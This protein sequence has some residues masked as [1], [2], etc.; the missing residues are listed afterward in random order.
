MVAAGLGGVRVESAVVPSEPPGG[1]IEGAWG[2]GAPPPTAH[3]DPCGRGE[4]ARPRLAAVRPGRAVHRPAVVPGGRQGPGVL[5]DSRRE[6]RARAGC[7][8]WDRVVPGGESAARVA[9]RRSGAGSGA[10][11]RRGRWRRGAALRPRPLAGA[12]RPT[13]VV[14]P[15]G[16][17]GCLGAQR[18]AARGR[19]MAGAAAVARPGAVRRRRRAVPPRHRLLHLHAAAAAAGLR[20]AAVHPA[21]DVAGHRRELVPARR[22]PAAAGG[23]AGQS[24]G[25][26]APVA[27]AR[28]RA[29]AQDLGLPAGPVLTGV[30][31]PWGGDRCLLHRR[32]RAAPGAAPDGAAG[33]GLRPA[34]LRHDPLARLPAGRQRPGA[35]R[36]VVNPGWRHL[37]NDRAALPGRAAGAAAGAA[38]HP[39]QPRRHPQGV[40]AGSRHDDRVRRRGAPASRSPAGRPGHGRQ[41]PPVGA[42][43][44]QDRHPEPAGDRPVLPVQR[45]RRRP[46]PDRGH[47]APGDDLR[48]RRRPAQPGPVRA[49]LAEP[50]PR[51]HPRLWGGGRPG[52][53]RGGVGTAVVCGQRL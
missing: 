6:V 18:R 52:Q 17:G 53:H 38:V 15:G 25:T 35:V 23:T 5:E 44:A 31:A 28:P 42:R 45:C 43:R 41:R 1:R 48:P 50:A 40:R 4:P 29:A 16:V 51:L 33:A 36:A 7:R 12:A 32:A 13:P 46:L 49:D 3:A 39:A 2:G 14:A 9:G 10:A 24:R 47:A 30:L 22:D 26:R 20:L 11:A 34:G 21:G 37:P 8:G 19:Q 27:A